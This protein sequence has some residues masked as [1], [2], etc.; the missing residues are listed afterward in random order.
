MDSN[1]VVELFISR[2]LIDRSLGQ[3]VLHEVDNSGKE[4]A[5]ILADYQ[6]INHKDDI[7]P[8]VAS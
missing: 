5:E 8:V 2:G 6:V 7:W 3:D 4:A 1:Q